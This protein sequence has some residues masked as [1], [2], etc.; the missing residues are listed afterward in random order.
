MGYTI[1]TVDWRFTAFFAWN[2]SS[3]S[4]ARPTVVATVELYDHRMDVPGSAG[5]EAADFYEDINVADANPGVVQTLLAQLEE[6]FGIP[7]V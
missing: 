6:A 5:F 3:L 7:K 2:G 1:R 4:P